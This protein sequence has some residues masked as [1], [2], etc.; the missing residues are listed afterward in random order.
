MQEHRPFGGLVGGATLLLT[1]VGALLWAS[2]LAGPVRLAT[3]LIEAGSHLK[4]ADRAASTASFKKLRYESLAAQSSARRAEAG[5]NASS[6]LM[7]LATVVPSVDAG[8]KETPHLISAAQHSADAAVRSL[9]IGIGLVRGKDKVIAPD[10][11][12]EGKMILLDRIKEVGGVVRE[13]RDDI[14]ASSDE[15][16][17]INVLNLPRRL[18]PQISQGIRRTTDADELL[19]KV[20]RGLDLLPAILGAERKR[21]YL[22]A[23]QNSA[24]QRGTGGAILRFETLQIENGKPLLPTTAEDDS[25]AGGS[26]YKIDRN[27][28]QLDIPL[29]KGAW[30]VRAIADAQRFG[31]SNWSPDWPLSSQ[32][33]IEYAKESTEVC[34][35]EQRKGCPRFPRVDGVVA[36]DPL[37]VREIMPGIGP[38][39]T[40]FGGHRV[41]RNSVVNLLLSK[42]Y[43][44]YP[45]PGERRVFLGQIVSAFFKRMFSPSHPTELV[46]GIGKALAKKH[47]QIW[48]AD[49]DEQAFIKRME[50]DGAISQ[51][52]KGGDYLYVV[53][54]NV[55]G[56]KLDY[57]AS[58]K[59]EMDIRLSNHDATISAEVTIHNGIRLPQPRWVLGD[60]KSVHRPM[61]NFYVPGNAKLLDAQ[62]SG[63]KLCTPVD[64]VCNGRLDTPAPAVWEAGRPQ[65]TTNGARRCGLRPCR[66][67]ST[68]TALSASITVCPALSTRGVTRAST[69]WWSSVSQR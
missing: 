63:K 3:G 32:L 23:F 38:F 43:T 25:E 52:V 67:P 68:R 6:P 21:R 37:A 33:A 49:P 15:L 61:M 41:S 30:Y 19:S 36:V 47:I 39:R 45:F 48:M 11:S 17:A 35:R 69:G 18:R 8:L 20:Q 56:N 4:K 53:E 22:L 44:T 7:D 1:L 62:V 40:E 29:P 59:N 13:I 31:N 12:G 50:W 54:Q 64:R 51:E 28:R 57:T 9:E 27:R 2:M 66:S 42:A 16:V 55:G 60:S 58:Q 24:E 5:F 14:Q 26:V 65:N 34:L 10:P 46:Q